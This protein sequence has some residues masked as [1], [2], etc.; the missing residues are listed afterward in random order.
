MLQH[1]PSARVGT[2]FSEAQIKQSS[3][4]TQDERWAV[5]SWS[6]IGRL[7]QLD[8]PPWGNALTF[9]R[10]LLLFPSSFQPAEG[11]TWVTQAHEHAGVRQLR[12][13]CR[14]GNAGQLKKFGRFWPESGRRASVTKCQP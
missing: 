10:N 2:K 4:Q 5:I 14:H 12:L 1:F 3:P 13:P 7:G 6:V 11:L 8:T 9:R